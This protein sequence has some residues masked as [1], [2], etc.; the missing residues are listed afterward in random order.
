MCFRAAFGVRLKWGVFF[1]LRSE[2]S[3]FR[4]ADCDLHI[5]GLLNYVFKFVLFEDR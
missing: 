2:F 5:S 4:F 3:H 1:G